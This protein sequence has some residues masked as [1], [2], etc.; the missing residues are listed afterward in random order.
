MIVKRDILHCGKLRKLKALS[1]NPAALEWLVALWGYC[2]VNKQYRFEDMS[3][4]RLADACGE[5]VLEGGK[6]Q[7]FLIASRWVELSGKTLVVRKFEH[8]NAG[9][10]QKLDASI[11]SAQIRAERAG[12]Q[13]IPPANR[14]SSARSASGERPVNARQP[15]NERMNERRARERAGELAVGQ[16]IA[17]KE[18]EFQPPAES[19]REYLLRTG[20]HRPKKLELFDPEKE[21]ARHFA[22]H[23]IDEKSW[24]FSGQTFSIGS[25]PAGHKPTPEQIEI[26]RIRMAAG[27][28]GVKKALDIRSHLPENSARDANA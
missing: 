18:K 24:S 10:F 8:Y 11:K 7:A 5:V 17:E 12:K 23:Q 26:V 1:G 16:G 4:D 25:Y 13:W 19:D 3:P 20:F 15:M 22:F 2:E 6:L 9:L 21:K 14:P 27:M 28:A